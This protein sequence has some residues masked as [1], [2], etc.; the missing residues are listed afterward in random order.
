MLFLC[1]VLKFFIENREKVIM[2]LFS[3]ED[4]QFYWLMCYNRMNFYLFFTSFFE[5]MLVAEQ[6]GDIMCT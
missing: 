4:V 2:V 3:H 5:K 6:K 1:S